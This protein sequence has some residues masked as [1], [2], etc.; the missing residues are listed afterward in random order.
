MSLEP[1]PFS[2]L[3]PGTQAG[4]PGI[5]GVPLV[6]GYGGLQRNRTLTYYPLTGAQIMAWPPTDPAA[7]PITATQNADL[8]CALLS[9]IDTDA[10]GMDDALDN[11][12]L[13]ANGPDLPDAGGNSQLDTDGDGFGNICDADLVNT[14]GLFTVNLSDF[15][16]F[17]SVF[18]QP[19]PGVAPFTMADHADFNGDGVVNLSEFSIFRAYF[20]GPPGPSG[21]HPLP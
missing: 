4:P 15:S 14:D 9:G 1:F 17:R 19:A 21:R 8:F 10:D 11:C 18:G 6:P 3:D 12:T 16:A 7:E 20:G 2:A 13:V 5:G